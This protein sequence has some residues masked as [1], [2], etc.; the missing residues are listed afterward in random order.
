[1]LK[2]SQGRFYLH[3]NNSIVWQYVATKHGCYIHNQSYKIEIN[4][5]ILINQKFK[6]AKQVNSDKCIYSIYLSY[7][8]TDE[9]NSYRLR[10]IMLQMCKFVKCRGHLCKCLGLLF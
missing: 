8:W 2:I 9:V 4:K 6:S 1:M 10:N 7:S 5:P 3:L